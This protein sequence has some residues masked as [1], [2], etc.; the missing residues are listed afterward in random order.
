[1]A[2]TVKLSQVN[3]NH[4]RFSKIESDDYFVVGTKG[5][6]T[7]STVITREVIADITHRLP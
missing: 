5:V 3:V 7:D 6:A 2:K 4:Q 1:M